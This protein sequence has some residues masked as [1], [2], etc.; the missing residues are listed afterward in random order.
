MQWNKFSQLLFSFLMSFMTSK[1]Q[2]LVYEKKIY[3]NNSTY[4]SNKEK[5][6]FL[7]KQKLQYYNKFYN[8]TYKRVAIRDQKSRWGSCS[9][10]GNLNFNFRVIFLPEHLQNYLIVHELCHLKEM[11]HKKSFWK[12]VAQTIPEYK[13]SRKELRTIR[14]GVKY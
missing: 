8:F 4:I 2:F 7:V 3:R 12:L 1:K 14:F 9:S 11:N 6:R 13:S 10:L 5:A